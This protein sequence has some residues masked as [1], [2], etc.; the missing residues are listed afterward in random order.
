MPL[1]NL[2]DLLVRL[3]LDA[4]EFRKGLAGASSS[5]KKT[6][7]KFQAEGR[8]LT[9]AITAPLVGLA[10]VAVVSAARFETAMAGVAKTLDTTGLSADQAD[11]FV[12]Q[13]GEGFRE[14]SQ[15]IPFSARELANIGE[16]A[17]QL[18]VAREDV[19]EF[20]RV[21]A[22]MG[23]ST[24]LS[25]EEAATS[26]ARF[27]SITRLPITRIEELGNVIVELGNRL[28][29][30]ESEV[31]TLGLRLAAAGTQAGLSQGEILAFA[32]ALSS[33]GVEA[34]AGGTAFSKLFS[35]IHDAVL[36][37]G[38][39]LQIFAAVAGTS[40]AEFRR[41]YEEDAAGAIQLFV[42]GLGRMVARGESTTKV[43]EGL[44]LQDERLKR[45]LLSL[46]GAGDKLEQSLT[47]QNKALAEGNAL[48]VEAERFYGTST[49]QLKILR[50]ALENAAIELGAALIPALK[51]LIPLAKGVTTQLAAMARWFAG[52]PEPVQKTAIAIAGIFAAIGPSLWMLGR[53]ASG[54]G[55]VLKLFTVGKY[56]STVDTATK[57]TTGLRVAT[58]TLGGTLVAVLA[59]ISSAIIGL[60]EMG[61]IASGAAGK[62]ETLI[63][64]LAH[65]VFAGPGLGLKKIRENAPS[66]TPDWI[67]DFF[68]QQASG[69]G[70]GLAD[71]IAGIERAARGA[72]PAVGELSEITDELG[73]SEEA[74]TVGSD[75]LAAAMAGTGESAAGTTNQLAELVAQLAMEAQEAG[76]SARQILELNL[77]RLGA[78]D[79]IRQEA[80]ALFDLGVQRQAA[81]DGLKAQAAMAKAHGE[82]IK[83]VLKALSAETKQLKSNSTAYDG[84]VEAVGGA[85]TAMEEN[86]DILDAG[87]DALR[88]SEDAWDAI[89]D[90]IQKDAR[91]AAEAVEQMA[92]RTR[93]SVFDMA[94]DIS[95]GFL[96]PIR[97]AFRGLQDAFPMSGLL[98]KVG[99]FGKG[100]LAA[101]GPAGAIFGA[102]SAIGK[103]F[104]VNLLDA[105]SS[106]LTS[107][108]H[109]IEDFFSWLTGIGGGETKQFGAQ[110]GFFEQ[111]QLRRFTAESDTFKAILKQLFDLGLRG[112]ELRDTGLKILGTAIGQTGLNVEAAEPF[113]AEKLLEM[114]KV[115]QLVE[116]FGLEGVENARRLLVAL[117]A[118]G[119]SPV[120][121]LQIVADLLKE[122]GPGADMEKVFADA[123]LDIEQRDKAEFLANEFG[124]EGVK[125]AEEFIL[126]LV[127]AGKTREEIWTKL[128]DI[129]LRAQE[130][131]FD[132]PEELEEFFA[133]PSERNLPGTDVPRPH[134]SEPLG[135]DPAGSRVPAGTYRAPTA[136]TA[137]TADAFEPPV[138]WTPE[139]VYAGLGVDLAAIGDR[140][141]VD[142]AML[143]DET[144]A[145]REAI[146][147]QAFM[148]HEFQAETTVRIDNRLYID[149][150]EAAQVIGE[151]IIQQV[152]TE[153]G[154]TVQNK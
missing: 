125:S 3:R 153:L 12:R 126:S 89:T 55:A 50:S 31:T 26:M 148:P 59:P 141:S 78:T 9:A 25:T 47:L 76:K 102:V 122:A 11:A 41:A 4:T 87:N 38:K 69:E 23:V 118:E 115:A 73:V 5:L 16:I 152:Y 22:A 57:A 80:L 70:G 54:L 104:G 110:F 21:I 127:K 36:D 68:K 53:M 46:A 98:E 143:R 37:G 44:E 97:N 74:A 85:I 114:E 105:V 112:D 52:L 67:P 139:S 63:A 149:G 35:R 147:L 119:K 39:Q 154:L 103:L 34:E 49:N 13:L 30:T 40:A 28:E 91:E 71:I 75:A 144:I 8:G 66:D 142:L 96:G 92:D 124:L 129:I 88:Q 6:G 62:I 14:L 151:H 1:G 93:E 99:G 43:L 116:H 113:F 19:L 79:A 108:G 27:A 32:A 48:S 135:G 2:A 90:T 94:D 117:I 120:E 56:A 24:D 137:P 121:V 138:P 77:Q 100:L 17:G 132:T 106:T 45:A 60:R 58:G 145:V 133:D 140:M 20:T 82:A 7:E 51:D 18:G 130:L 33:V 95:G 64:L 61:R 81:A 107:M 10:T 109:K 128:A 29:T 101:A 86:I 65:P 15:E 123:I 136:S 42:E 111:A 84:Y 150:R 131:G 83:K 146:E 72:A 134:P